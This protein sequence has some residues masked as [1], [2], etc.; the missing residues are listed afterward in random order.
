MAFGPELFFPCFFLWEIQPA[1]AALEA[2]VFRGEVGGGLPCHTTRNREEDRER[3]RDVEQDAEKRRAGGWERE[4]T[5]RRRSSSSQMERDGTIY[6]AIFGD[7]CPDSA[8]YW[9]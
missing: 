1:E 7:N 3:R 5:R 4:P 9:P 8:A 6:Q 2:G